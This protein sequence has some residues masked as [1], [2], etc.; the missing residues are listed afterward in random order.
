MARI[1]QEKTFLQ[2]LGWLAVVAVTAWLLWMTMRPQ[3]QVTAELVP[4]AAPAVARGVSFG[5]LIDKV[6]NVLVFVP[7]GAAAALALIG[8]P[9]L[10]RLLASTAGGAA[11][12]AAIEL[13]QHFIPGRDSAL[14]DWLLNTAGAFIGA[15]IVATLSHRKPSQTNTQ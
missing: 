6:G 3:A 7:L 4:L 11:L 15:A 2:R 12:S 14:K 13:A 10:T 9:R 5:F 8:K 1:L